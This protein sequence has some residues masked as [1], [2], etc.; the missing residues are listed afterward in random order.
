MW[1]TRLLPF[2]WPIAFVVGCFFI[3]CGI[4]DA[5]KAKKK[6]FKVSWVNKEPMPD[7]VEYIREYDV[8]NYTGAQFNMGTTLLFVAWR[9]GKLKAYCAG[10]EQKPRV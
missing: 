6:E 2:A 9:D 3:A 10:R 1:L 8:P 5:C 4:S 7:G